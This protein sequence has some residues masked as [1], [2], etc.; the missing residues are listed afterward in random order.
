MAYNL[1][2]GNATGGQKASNKGQASGAPTANV[3]MYNSTFVNC[4]YRQIQTGRG[5]NI[6]FEEGASGK[7]YNNLAVNCKFGYRVVNTPVADTANLFYG[8]NYQYADS[9]SLANQFFPTGY[10]TRPRTTDLPLPSS[11]LP[12]NYTLGAVYN[13]APVV[14]AGNPLFI[15]YPLPVTGGIKLRDISTMGNFNFRLQASSPCIGKGYTGLNLAPIQNITVNAIFGVTYYPQPGVDVGCY[16]FN[17]TG[18]N[19]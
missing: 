10:I 17:G 16:Q 4:G 6:N 9:L 19:H 7:F 1:F 11:Y 12:S 8:N 2:I 5:A 13:G 18:N 3:V 15:N 14:Q